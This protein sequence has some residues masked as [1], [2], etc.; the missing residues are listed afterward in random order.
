MLAIGNQTSFAAL[1]PVEPFDYAV[2]SGF[3]AFEWF[4]DRHGASGWDE[5]DLDAARRRGIRAAA[6][7]HGIR[8]SVHARL[9]AEAFQP[10]AETLWRKDIELAQDLGAELLNIHLSHDHGMGAFI[11]AITPLLH[12]TDD[13]GLAL[14]IENT[15][16]HSPQDFNGLFAGLRAL[17][18]AP[19]GHVG[20]CF[21]LGH[22]NLCASTR[23]DYLRFLDRLDPQVPIHHLHLHENWGDA[24]THLTLFTGPS[25]GDDAGIRSVLKRLRRRGFSGL[26][27]LEQWPTPRDLLRTAHDRLAAL[28]TGLEPG[29]GKGGAPKE[30]KG[31]KMAASET[32]TSVSNRAKLGLEAGGDPGVG[33]G[34]HPVGQAAPEPND[35]IAELVEANRRCRSW[36]EQLE[37]VRLLLTRKVPPLTP[38]QLTD[39]AIYLRFLGTGEIRCEEDGRHFRPAHHAR[40][41]RQ[42]RERLASLTT[43]ETALIVRR[44]YP[45]LPSSAPA[46]QRAEPL[47]RIRDIAHRNDLP[48]D[49]KREIKESLQNKLHRCAGPEDL[50]V[51]EALL[52]RLTAPGASYT[53]DFV[54]Q[55]RVFHGELKEFFNARSLD[56]ELRAMLETEPGEAGLIRRFLDEKAAGVAAVGTGLFQALTDLR[57]WFRF[58][59]GGEAGGAEAG[60][61]DALTRWEE[62]MLA[63][64][65]LED[66]AFVVLSEHINAFEANPEVGWPELVEMLSLA[67]ENAVLTGVEPEE[68]KAIRSELQAWGA[69]GLLGRDPGLRLKATVERGRRMAESHSERVIALFASRAEKLG[70]ALG[71]AEYAARVFGEAEVRGNFLFQ[72]S[73]LCTLMGRRLRLDLGQ[74][75][76]DVLVSGRC[77]GYVR[78]VDDLAEPGPAPFGPEIWLVRRV[79]GDEEIPP[80]VVGMVLGHELAHLSHLA[81]RAR[82]AEV[83]LVA[84]EETQGLIRLE[85]TSAQWIE[86]TATAEGV[87]WQT[88]IA[89]PPEETE[90]TPKPVR[91]PKSRL[92]ARPVILPVSEATMERAGGKADGLRRLAQLSLQPGAGFQTA[93]ALVVPFGVMET[94]LSSEPGREAE[95]LRLRGELNGALVGRGP[96]EPIE[97]LALRLSALVAELE[98]PTEITSAV[99]ARFGAAARLMVRSSANC[100]DLERLAGAGLYDSVTNVTVAAVAEAVKAVWASL[101]TRRAALSRMR[102][103]VAHEAVHMAVVIQEMV[104]PQ[105]SFVLHT[106]NPIDGNREEVYAEIAVGLGETLVGGAARGN[107]CRLLCPKHSGLVKTLAFANFSLALEPCSAGVVTRVVDYSQVQLSRDRGW[108]EELGRRLGAIGAVVED[109]FRCPQDIEGAILGDEIFLVQ[110]RAQSGLC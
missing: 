33:V 34:A 88:T 27:I 17:A 4:P 102:A 84:C 1:S 83:V 64:I 6:E 42:I 39:L 23:N 100:E 5:A 85:Q 43:P 109:A 18:D 48:A 30:T 86:L 24:D 93:P 94:T 49:L 75:G 98:V 44:I 54:E 77:S 40:I 13:A 57:R 97:N 25:A 7:A 56:D 96:A 91:I 47:T 3:G 16:H 74:G 65:G 105:F 59:L 60:R 26:V 58:L 73:R 8:M 70:Q 92:A 38:G 32:M 22:A 67:F 71:V 89:G 68:A 21:D 99:A 37:A 2:A 103:G 63:D 104:V 28:W 52:A 72:V 80:R 90:S 51:A 19:V 79:A 9:Q 15:P 31:T 78:V 41:A 62:R 87:R 10:G 81:V 110:A 107:P 108:R 66:Y 35:L 101:W 76:W 14:S 106:T 50:V 11:A 46:F 45:W 55:F 12:W 29:P 95:Y 20:M 82:Q 69:E 61:M 36:R 53:P